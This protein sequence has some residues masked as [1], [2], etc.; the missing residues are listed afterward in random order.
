MKI[1][2][3]Y[4]DYYDYLQGIYGID[5]NLILDRIKFSPIS[6]EYDNTIITLYICDYKIQGVDFYQYNCGKFLSSN[7]IPDTESVVSVLDKIYDKIE[8]NLIGN[9][10]IDS[11]SLI[12][13]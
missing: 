6:Y 9:K 10:L 5:N 8:Q 2:S 13:T 11:K 3:K 7:T 1:I 12:K 4:K